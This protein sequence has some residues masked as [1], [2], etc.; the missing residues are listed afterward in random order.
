MSDDAEPPNLSVEEVASALSVDDVLQ[1]LGELETR[2]KS[3][4][5]TVATLQDTKQLE[6]RITEKVAAK[7]PKP[8]PAFDHAGPPTLRDIALPIPDARSLLQAAQSTWTFFEMLGEIKTMLWMLLDRRYSMAWPTRFTAVLLLFFIVTSHWWIPIAGWDNFVGRT[9]DKFLDLA[10][11]LVL[12]L[13]L[14]FESRR[15]KSWM[16][17]RG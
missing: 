17:Q 3:L 15:Y 11:A 1:L 7:I 16:K 5:G 10:L 14:S 8:E 12:F 2:V 13:F 6:E 4:E 9:F